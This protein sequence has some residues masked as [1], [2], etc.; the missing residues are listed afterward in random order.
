MEKLYFTQYKVPIGLKGDCRVHTQAQW[1]MY[2]DKQQCEAKEATQLR[3]PW[4]GEG[5]AF[6]K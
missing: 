5:G 4:I 1:K 2:S 3:S 6:Q